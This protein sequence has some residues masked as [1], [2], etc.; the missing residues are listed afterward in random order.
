MALRGGAGGNGALSTQ[1]GAPL[2][3]LETPFRLEVLSFFRAGFLS[4]PSVLHPPVHTPA[5]LPPLEGMFL[6]SPSLP[7]SVDT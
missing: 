5:P 7:G 6:S 3:W 1:A 2:Q 4:F